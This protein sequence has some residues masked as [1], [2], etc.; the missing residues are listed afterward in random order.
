MT[1]AQVI[2]V[3]IYEAMSIV[4]ASVII[5]FIIGDMVSITL[6]LQAC[7]FS[8]L[9]FTFDFPTLLFFSVVGMSIIVS[10]TGSY[11]PARVLQEKRIASALKNL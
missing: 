5:G 6:T 7:L 11:L 10:I 8:E 3:Y 4:L 2:R 9:P 1:A